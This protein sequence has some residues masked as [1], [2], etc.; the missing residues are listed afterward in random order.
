MNCHICESPVSPQAWGGAECEVCGSVSV[1]EIPTPEVLSAYY[2]RYAQVYTGGGQSGGANM[3]RYAQRYLKLVR[4]HHSGAPALLLDVGS[5]NNPFPGLA[6]AAGWKTTMVDFTQPKKPEAAVEFVQGHLGQD[7]L[8]QGFAGQFDVVTC[9]AVLEH[10]PDPVAAV[11]NLAIA[12]KPGG[13]VL[14]STP[15]IGTWL[16]S[17]AIG[18][19]MWFFLPEHLHLISPQGMRGLFKQAGLEQRAGGR[20]ELNAWRYAARYGLGLAEALPGAAAKLVAGG[21][22]RRQRAQ[23]GQRFKGISWQAFGRP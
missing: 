12:C 20:L 5:S 1:A 16:T 14:L 11:T 21:W 13:V 17:S 6:A 10:V 7:E 22:W 3:L 19:S 23:R 9:W 8:F 2:E 15:E 18:R 4:A